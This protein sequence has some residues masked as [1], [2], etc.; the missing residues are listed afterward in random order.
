MRRV[1]LIVLC[2]G[3][4]LMPLVAASIVVLTDKPVAEFTLPDGSVLKNAYVWKRSSE[5]LMIIHDEGQ[6][7]L[8]FRTLPDDWRAAYAVKDEI[9]QVEAAASERDDQYL[10][11]DVIPKLDGLDHQAVTFYKSSRYHG[12]VDYELLT[13][14]A[15]RSLI[16]NPT[17]AR[18]ICA[19]IKRIFPDEPQIEIDA[20]YESCG[21]CNAVGS[22]TYD[23]P[24]CDGSGQCK[25][26][27]GDGE[28]DAEFNHADPKHC[29]TCRGT[30]KCARCRGRGTITLQCNECKGQ[31]RKLLQDKV[32]AQLAVAVQR[33]NKFHADFGQ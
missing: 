7:Y 25:A 6:Y 22:A 18:R 13:A 27:G 17:K 16:D 24:T 30:G 3:M 4:A 5:G 12:E 1:F 9:G 28:L 10:I 15:L 2:A 11:F 26:C 31:G 14:C 21:A 33:L 20:F 8:N 19:D 29:T 23:C 32:M